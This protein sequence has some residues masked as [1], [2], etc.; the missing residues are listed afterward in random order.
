MNRLRLVSQR[1]DILHDHGKDLLF[2]GVQHNTG[3]SGH[4]L[5]VQIEFVSLI[6][7][8]E[9]LAQGSASNT[10]FLPHDSE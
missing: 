4:A 5:G 6:V 3:P 8:G 7:Q 1:S 2:E 10:V 9:Y